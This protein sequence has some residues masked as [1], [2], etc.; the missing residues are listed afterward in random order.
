MAVACGKGPDP[1]CPSRAMARGTGEM[2]MCSLAHIHREPFV[3]ASSLSFL[4]LHLSS[5]G[6]HSLPAGWSTF[7]LFPQS[8]SFTF[9]HSFCLSIPCELVCSF[10]SPTS[11]LDD[12]LPLL[13]SFF[14]D[15]RLCLLAFLRNRLLALFLD[16]P[17][18]LST[19]PALLSSRRSRSTYS[20]LYTPS[21]PKTQPPK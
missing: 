3:I 20:T 15:K 16:I 9:C 4:S 19:L 6:P 14:L 12:T 8:L 17:Y 5:S 13:I 11:N 1:G 21:L 18:S 7:L 2:C 10:T